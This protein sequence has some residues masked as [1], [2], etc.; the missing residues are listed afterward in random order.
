MKT[1]NQVCTLEQAKRLKQL[2]IEERKDG[3]WW[4]DTSPAEGEIWDDMVEK[5][6]RFGTQLK[7]EDATSR[8]EYIKRNAKVFLYIRHSKWDMGITSFSMGK[9]LAGDHFAAFTVAEL[10]VMLPPEIAH[11]YNSL[12]SYY[13][14]FGYSDTDAGKMHYCGYE[15]NDLF[16][17]EELLHTEGG[18]SEADVRAKMLIW[19]LENNHTTAEEV[20]KRLLE[21]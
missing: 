2:G 3:F 19:L 8:D 21:E 7:L 11:K 18:S 10:G 1:E 5:S 6:T 4:A 15:D 20:N 12:S 17:P 13:V 16:M 14:M 9:Y